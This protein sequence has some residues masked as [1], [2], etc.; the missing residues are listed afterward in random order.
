MIRFLSVSN[1]A[2]VERLDLELQPGLTV[3]TGETGAGKSIVLGALNLLV[4]GRAAGDLV[5]TGADRAV[6]EAALDTDDGDEVVLR[7]EVTVQGRSHVFIDGALATVGALRALGKRLVDFHGQHQHQTL[8]DPRTHLSLL[9]AHGRLADAAAAVAEA[10]R[11]WRAAAASLRR[12]TLSEKE[13]ADRVELLTFQRKEIDDVGPRAGEDESLAASRTRLASAER[14]VELC[15]DAYGAVYEQDGA[16]LATLGGVWRRL[17]ELASI[18]PAFSEHLTRRETIEAQLEDLA[19]F[20]RSYA[21]DIDASPEKLDA[22]ETR[23]A[24]MERLKKQYGPRLDDVL[25]HRRRI[26]EELETLAGRTERVGRLTR[27]EEQARQAYFDVAR[28]LS[29]RRRDAA[30]DL[31][32]RLV[33]VLDSLAMPHARVH[34][35]FQGEPLPPERWSEAGIDEVELHFSPNP[36]EAQRPLARIASGGELSRVMLGLKTLATN[37][38]PG[39]TLIFD[40]VDAGIG[41]AAADRVGRMLRALADRFQVLCVTHLAQIAVHATS[42]HHVSKHVRNGRTTTS[43]EKLDE[44]GRVAELARLMTGATSRAAREGARSLLA[45]K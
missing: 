38:R 30:D 32:A 22:I 20:L 34:P 24:A 10:F 18:D 19:F 31:G 17:E 44:Q 33:P 3:L 21:A 25:E 35:R 1:L 12:A 15:A 9:D 36:G 16:V 43:V 40:E 45:G 23:I 42:H 26:G 39:K 37:D 8:L 28:R 6:V 7:R 2:I 11:T 27:A 13:R 5:R 4:G 14:L 41:G 29:D